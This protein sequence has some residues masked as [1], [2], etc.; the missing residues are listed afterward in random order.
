MN[1]LHPTLLE[2]DRPS[3]QATS[4]NYTAISATFIF[5]TDNSYQNRTLDTYLLMAVL[6]VGKL[7]ITGL[8]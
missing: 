1:D 5:D 7:K 4:C 2:L 8:Q 3:L 6:Y